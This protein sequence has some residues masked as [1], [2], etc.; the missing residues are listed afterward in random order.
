MSGYF[1]V[2][3]ENTQ[4]NPEKEDVKNVLNTKWTTKKYF[5]LP[6]NKDKIL[7]ANDETGFWSFE[8]CGTKLSFNDRNKIIVESYY[9]ADSNKFEGNRV[10]LM[11]NGSVIRVLF[12]ENSPAHFNFVDNYGFNLKFSPE[13][14]DKI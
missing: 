13:K 8:N 6:E 9:Y 10:Y 14:W 5:N 11:N 7:I 4:S 12:L 3:N 2:G 1:Q